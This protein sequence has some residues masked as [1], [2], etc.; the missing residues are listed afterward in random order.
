VIFFSWFLFFGVFNVMETVVIE[1]Q[2]SAD[3]NVAL[4]KAT[5]GN[6]DLMGPLRGP[7]L[8][9]EM[10]NANGGLFDGCYVQINGDDW[11]NW[12]C[13]LTPEQDYEYLSSVILRK[14]GLTK[15]LKA[16]YFKEYPLSQMPIQGSDVIISCEVDG[17]PAEF[18][19]S[20]TKN[21]NQLPF[22]GNSCSI[23]NIQTGDNGIYQVLVSNTQGSIS[24]AA[25]IQVLELSAP[26]IL[27]Q[28]INTTIGSGSFGQLYTT[29][30]GFPVPSY[31]WNKDGNIV[32]GAVGASLYINNMQPENVGFYN[33][34]VSNSQGTVTSD[35]VELSIGQVVISADEN[36]A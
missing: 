34:V 11:Q 12:P 10:L 27:V 16:P 3:R 5:L 20:W 30:N 19:Y 33:V 26:S 29:A 6:F 2:P 14:L 24:G 32:D 21:D 8:Y 22:T 18:T 9:V 35:T 36:I 7:C 25:S 15:R 4:L 23:S 17:N 1:T 28:P 31:Q 13:N